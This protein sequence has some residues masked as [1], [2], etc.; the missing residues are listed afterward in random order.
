VTALPLAP[1]AAVAT[2]LAL[3]AGPAPALLPI[4]GMAIG[5]A[6]ASLAMVSTP[7]MRRLAWI[8]AAA[9]A[10]GAAIRIVLPAAPA[11]GVGAFAGA[12]GEP[13]RTA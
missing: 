5:L 13:L 12:R 1:A 6:C 11:S 8:A 3:L 4:A 10:V 7:R 9:I 2:A